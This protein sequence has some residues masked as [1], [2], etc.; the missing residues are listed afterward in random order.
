[1]L[2]QIKEGTNLI[3][4]FTPPLTGSVMFYRRNTSAVNSASCSNV[5]QNMHIYCYNFLV[6]CCYIHVLTTIS[7][8]KIHESAFTGTV[9]NEFQKTGIFPLDP[10]MFPD[11][12]H[13]PEETTRRHKQDK[14]ECQKSWRRSKARQVFK[15]K[16]QNRTVTQACRQPMKDHDK[17]TLWLEGKTITEDLYVDS[18]SLSPGFRGSNVKGG[19]TITAVD[20]STC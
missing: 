19:P 7:V 4:C 16:K 11:W 12:R 8:S 17:E 6:N 2:G 18:H 9:V 15:K 10:N 13:E 1:M 5:R 3:S 20:L 14:L